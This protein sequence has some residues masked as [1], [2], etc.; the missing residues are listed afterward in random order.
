MGV[1]PWIPLRYL[2]GMVLHTSVSASVRVPDCG[3]E[4]C[5]LCESAEEDKYLG[6]CEEE[7]VDFTKARPV[8]EQ[9]LTFD[10]ESQMSVNSVDSLHRLL[11]YGVIIFRAIS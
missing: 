5:K 8:S 6:R 3:R 11:D 1:F 7:S 4:E 9:R 2:A 10:T